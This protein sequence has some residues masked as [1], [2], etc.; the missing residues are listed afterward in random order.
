[1]NVFVA[2]DNYIKYFYFNGEAYTTNT[3]VELDKIYID[4]HYYQGQRMWKYA[5]YKHTVC[6][7][8]GMYLFFNLANIEFDRDTIKQSNQCCGYFL[9]PTNDIQLAIKQIVTPIPIVIIPVVRKKD[10][11]SKEVMIGWCI[12]IGVLLVSLIFTIWYLI[13][14]W[15]TIL[16]LIWRHDKL[17]G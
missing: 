9:L 11:E 13:W 6:I 5:R 12:Y 14:F 15:S 10:Y 16:F 4:T 8:G 7:D 2:K 3:I 1:M 17:R